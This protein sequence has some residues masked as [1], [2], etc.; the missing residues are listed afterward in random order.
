MQL[1]YKSA[2][3]Y[4][5]ANRLLYGRHHRTRYRG[6]AD[7]IPPG[8]SVVDLCCGPATLYHRFLRA[9]K[10]R[11]TGLDVSP[12]FIDAL[13]KHGGHGIV[14][15]LLSDKPLPRA[16]YIIIQGALYFFLPN[17]SPLI[18]RMLAAANREVIIAEAIRNLSSS[19]IPGIANLAKRLAGAAEGSDAVR[20]GEETLDQLFADYAPELKRSFKIPGGRDKVYVLRKAGAPVAVQ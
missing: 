7:L 18:E 1:I 14:W 10:V 13:N 5:I 12:S 20:F 6:I 11:Y 2:A 15:D 9:K 17:P 4:E 3:L 16:D 19:A 8:A